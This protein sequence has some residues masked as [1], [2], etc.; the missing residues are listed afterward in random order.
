MERTNWE[1]M[2][3]LYLIG[4]VGQPPLQ[5]YFISHHITQLERFR[6]GKLTF[7][8]DGPRHPFQSI[9]VRF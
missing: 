2:R 5:H 8:S 7:P 6:L 3:T 1:R 9:I 4:R